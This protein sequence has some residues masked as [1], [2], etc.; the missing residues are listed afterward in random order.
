MSTR[1]IYQFGP[2]SLDAVERVL[3]RDGQPLPIPPKDLE[4]LLV[5]VE[6]SGRLVEKSFLMSRVWPETF[7]EEGNLARHVSAI[8]SLLSGNVDGA[9]YIETI[10]KRGYRF[11]A[12]VERLDGDSPDSIP[13]QFL[14]KPSERQAMTVLP[15]ANHSGNLKQE[16]FSDGIR[17]AVMWS[18]PPGQIRA[19]LHTV[20]ASTTFAQAE[21]MRRF[22]EFIVEH[23]LSSPNEPLKE[24]IIGIELYAAHGEFDPRIT[25]VVRVD[26]T[27]LR[28]KLRE[29]YSSEGAADPL[30]IDL[31][32]G[33]Y[34][35]V[36]HEASVRLASQRPAMAGFA[37]PS[38]VVLPFSNLSPEPEDYFSDGLTE[39][40]IHALSS[41]RGIRVSAVPL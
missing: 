33:S 20:L 2:F 7:V 16:Y 1:A 37:E 38:I 23:T 8:R 21:R 13:A 29:Y 40:I 14:A 6:N 9:D 34:V 10:P 39:E 17:D 26:A 41:I 24:M 4:V 22:L 19:Q 36:F 25:S 27:R 11:V 32:K 18:Q 3:F 35:P 30:I 5:L 28:T 12:N 31:P 15:F